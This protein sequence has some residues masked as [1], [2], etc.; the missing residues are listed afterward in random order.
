M[1]GDFDFNPRPRK[2]GDERKAIA[3][4]EKAISIHALVKRATEVSEFDGQR[5]IISIHALVKRATYCLP[6]LPTLQAI[7]IHALVKR[8]TIKGEKSYVDD[9]YFNPRPRKEGDC[10][11]CK[12]TPVTAIS[13]HALVKRATTAPSKPDRV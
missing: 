7:S 5:G 13:I 4:A 1:A 11:E 6:T 9:L 2:E 12:M 10:T 8:A 3:L